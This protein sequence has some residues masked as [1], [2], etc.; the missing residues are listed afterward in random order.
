[1]TVLVGLDVLAMLRLC[2]TTYD[3]VRFGYR[4]RA[5]VELSDGRTA[6]V[7]GRTQEEAEDEVWRHVQAIAPPLTALG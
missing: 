4:W 3:P 6:E 2:E 1:M 5:R 7:L